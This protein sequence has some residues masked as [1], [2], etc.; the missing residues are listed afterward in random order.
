MCF[1]FLEVLGSSSGLFLRLYLFV[2]IAMGTGGG[3]L[4]SAKC[5]CIV[6]I[7]MPATKYDYL[8]R[9]RLGIL[10]AAAGFPELRCEE[11]NPSADYRLEDTFQTLKSA[12]INCCFLSPTIK[13]S[14]IVRLK[15]S[16]VCLASL[17]LSYLLSIICECHLCWEFRVVERKCSQVSVIRSKTEINFLLCSLE[18]QWWDSRARTGLL[19]HLC[20]S[21]VL[22]L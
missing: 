2:P 18:R 11:V 12:L 22:W 8:G 16:A 5:L 9:K 21:L 17:G 3:A 4:P 14:S 19:S 1:S 15:S 13:I 10:S 20:H 6:I 7:W